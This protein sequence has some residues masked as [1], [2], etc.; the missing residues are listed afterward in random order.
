MKEM[1]QLCFSVFFPSFK[2]GQRRLHQLHINLRAYMNAP[3]VPSFCLRSSRRGP[4]EAATR[5]GKTS[6][7][8]NVDLNLVNRN[9]ACHGR[10]RDIF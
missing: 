10:K 7:A 6:L 1:A 5:R 9:V 8:K 3:Y 2:T 4:R